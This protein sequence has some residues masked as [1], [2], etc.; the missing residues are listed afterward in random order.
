[1]PNQKCLVRA[2]SY[3]CKTNMQSLWEA[4]R[5]RSCTIC[6]RLIGAIRRSR[7]YL[8]KMVANTAN[9][10]KCTLIP[11]DRNL[12]SLPKKMKHILIRQH[13]Y[14]SRNGQVLIKYLL[15]GSLLT[16]SIRTQSRAMEA[17]V[18]IGDDRS[19]TCRSF[20]SLSSQTKPEMFLKLC[21][22]Q[23]L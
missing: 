20:Q 6:H 21:K 16:R 10:M 1:M 12:P 5:K 8:S 18:W 11:T 17:L 19:R 14:Q 15:T 2:I 23:V 3:E 22:N 13:M 4:A 9:W 7:L